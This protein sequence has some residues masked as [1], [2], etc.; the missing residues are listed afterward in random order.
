MLASTRL[1]A[2]KQASERRG[3]RE[4]TSAMRS[5][6][7]SRSP[8]SWLTMMVVPLLCAIQLASHV[9]AALRRRAPVSQRQPGAPVSAD[10]RSAHF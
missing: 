9:V 8:S 6:A 7:A 10:H 3:E 1:R 5:Q 4:R 2:R